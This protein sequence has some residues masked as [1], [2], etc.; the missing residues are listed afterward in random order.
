MIYMLVLYSQECVQFLK[1]IMISTN[2]NAVEGAI[3]HLQATL[4]NICWDSCPVFIKVSV[5]LFSFVFLL[6]SMD[7]LFK[8]NE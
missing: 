5:I 2:Y 8:S 6:W 1:E 7:L 3:Q 4:S